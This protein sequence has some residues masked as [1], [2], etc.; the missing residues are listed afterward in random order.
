[1]NDKAK[2]AAFRAWTDRLK[3]RI[4]FRTRVRILFGIILLLGLAGAAADLRP[5]TWLK[6]FDLDREYTVPA[7]FSG[8]LLLAAAWE[9]FTAASSKRLGA[10]SFALA[11]LF[12]EMGF[13]ELLMIHERIEQAAGVDWQ[14]L[15][16]PLMAFAGIAWLLVFTQLRDR[17]Q[18][19]LWIAGAVAWAA[20]QLFEAAE[21]GW[22]A[23]TKIPL[24]GYLYLVHVEELL[25]MSGS[26]C[27]LLTLLL[28][29]GGP[30]ISRK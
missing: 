2:D 17:R 4:A 26:S 9:S 21:W 3:Y 29:N 8:G 23:E 22:G 12:L 6:Y 27:F 28:L 15:Y 30:S 11:A 13:D 18:R 19:L 5:G 7:L 10:W 16:L 24:P 14:I 25:E 20:S 1:M